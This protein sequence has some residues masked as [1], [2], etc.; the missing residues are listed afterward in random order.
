MEDSTDKMAVPPNCSTDSVQ[1]QWI[2]AE[3]NELIPEFIWKCR[4]VRVSSQAISGGEKTE[5]IQTS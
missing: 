5:R 2:L 3:M 1:S 4:G